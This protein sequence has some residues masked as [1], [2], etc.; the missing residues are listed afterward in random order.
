MVEGTQN[1]R[2]SRLLR[3]TSSIVISTIR[4]PQSSP[5]PRRLSHPH[6]RLY[7][8]D[9]TWTPDWTRPDHR[10]DWYHSTDSVVHAGPCARSNQIDFDEETVFAAPRKLFDLARFG[11]DRPFAMVVSLTHPHDPFNIGQ[12]YWDHHGFPRRSRRDAR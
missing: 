10:P 3:L 9:F 4:K 1:H 6:F 7:P 8:A 2:Q 12:A 11:R 5:A